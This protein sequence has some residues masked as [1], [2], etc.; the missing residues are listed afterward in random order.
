MKIKNK[1]INIVFV[2]SGL[3]L[4]II[5]V[6][7]E[8][9]TNIGGVPYVSAIISK[10]YSKDIDIVPEYIVIH[11]TG[12]RG[13][14]ANAMANRNYFDTTDRECSTQ[15]LVDDKEIVQAVPDTKRAWH[16]GDL[17]PL[18]NATNSNSIGIELCVNS[19]GDFGVTFQHGIILTKY[20]MEK[21]N[22]P[23]ENVIR[24]HDAT[25]KICPRIMIEDDP[26]LW[27]RFKEEIS[28][29][30]IVEQV[31]EVKEDIIETP[32]EDIQVEEGA[33]ITQINLEDINTN[34]NTYIQP[35]DTNARVINGDTNVTLLPS[36][37]SEV[38]GFIKQGSRIK[39]KENIGNAY[40]RI[41]YNMLEGYIPYENIKLFDEYT[42]SK[43][44]E[45]KESTNLLKK[46]TKI[47]S[48]G[49]IS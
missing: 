40:C 33:P 4:G 48:F 49:M 36:D 18:T 39:I 1:I 7:A 20:L 30:N 29:P 41:E 3:L 44:G 34:T 6:Q 23:A 9:M 47:L 31:E 42:F 28:K 15:Y 14:G 45:V 11:D 32:A 16:I 21:Y 8:E 17:K 24:H 19:D 12:N 27:V 5:N 2:F 43:N 46:L 25:G 13:K 22:I 38:L 37:G 35:N 26:S 10:N